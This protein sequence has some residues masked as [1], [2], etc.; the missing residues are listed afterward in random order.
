MNRHILNRIKQLK[1]EIKIQLLRNELELGE[2]SQ[3]IEN[4][5]PQEY[6]LE[7]QENPEV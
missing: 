1:Q 3:K 4:F 5:D 6:L 2:K 7:L